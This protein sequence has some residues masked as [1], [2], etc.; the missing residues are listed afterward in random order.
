MLHRKPTFLLTNVFWV[1]MTA[2]RNLIFLKRL[3]V[4]VNFYNPQELT[5]K[6]VHIASIL[7][8]YFL[9]PENKFHEV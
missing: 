7:I 9:T 4:E 8:V 5:H 3:F 1:S 6:S 2:Q